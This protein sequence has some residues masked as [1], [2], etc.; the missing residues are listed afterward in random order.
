MNFF[1]TVRNFDNLDKAVAENYQ[2]T[3]LE[4][5]INGQQSHDVKFDHHDLKKI[6]YFLEK[7]DHNAAKAHMHAVIKKHFGNLHHGG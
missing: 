4:K 1:D 7:P 6:A 2:P 5:K 3:D